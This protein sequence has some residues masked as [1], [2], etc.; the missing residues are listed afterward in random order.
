MSPSISQAC[1]PVHMGNRRLE[2]SDRRRSR[3]LA[4]ASQWKGSKPRLEPPQ[5]G[6]CDAPSTVQEWLV[7]GQA[8]WDI[9]VVGIRPRSPAPGLGWADDRRTLLGLVGGSHSDPRQ[10]EASNA[11]SLTST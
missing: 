11:C 1:S 4:G 6:A 8:K 7:S 3:W 2:K 5:A 10:R 9:L